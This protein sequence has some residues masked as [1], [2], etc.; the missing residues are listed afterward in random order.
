LYNFLTIKYY[1][2]FHCDDYE[3]TCLKNHF[4]FYKGQVDKKAR[5]EWQTQARQF[6]KLTEYFALFRYPSESN[7]RNPIEEIL[8]I[9]ANFV[10]V[11]TYT[12]CF[13]Y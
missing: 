12:E 3:L 10:C 7:I 11:I 6:S 5:P 1:G 9:S 4:Q 2:T 13:K 8:L